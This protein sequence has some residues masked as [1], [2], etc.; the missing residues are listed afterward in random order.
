MLTM[1]LTAQILTQE[2]Q[3]VYSTNIPDP[4]KRAVAQGQAIALQLT[5][6]ECAHP[7]VFN[8]VAYRCRPD[9][10]VIIGI[11][12]NTQAGIYP[13]TSGT[14]VVAQL[15]ITPTAW[16]RIHRSARAS[17]KKAPPAQL[18]RDRIAKNTAFSA[19]ADTRWN[20]YHLRAPLALP[21][22]SEFRITDPFGLQRLYGKQTASVGHN[23]VDLAAPEQ[24]SWSRS[25]P[26]AQ[27]MASGVVVLAS[28][29]WVEGNTVVVYHGDSI[30]TSY[31]HLRIITVKRG[32]LVTP[33]QALG[34]VGSTGQSSGPHLHLTLRINGIN[35]DPLLARISLN[36]SLR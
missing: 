17:T 12:M 15:D 8:D 14:S 18:D 27:S 9:R 19:H 2:I 26:N 29:L 3:I 22:S 11:P 20:T 5:P 6:L 1:L 30:Y 28:R 13:V 32:E 36:E 35:V 21:L 7:I 16:Q 24:Q 31:C 34:V 4:S 33:G 10:F 25:A 23:G